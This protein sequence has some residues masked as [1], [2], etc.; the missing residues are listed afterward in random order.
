[1][2]IF[3]NQMPPSLSTEKRQAK[4]EADDSL[5][6]FFFFFFFFL[7]FHFPDKVSPDIS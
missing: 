4:F 3:I 5:I 6:F 7:L 1:M 2:N